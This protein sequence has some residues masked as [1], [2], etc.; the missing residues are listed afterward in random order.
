M[1]C[2]CG[3]GGQKKLMFIQIKFD[4]LFLRLYVYSL[5]LEKQEKQQELGN[6][7]LWVGN[8]ERGLCIHCSWKHKLAWTCF[9]KYLTES[10]KI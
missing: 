8:G 1:G 7:Q 2:I 9:Q 6:I 3:W 4:F 5:K 10:T